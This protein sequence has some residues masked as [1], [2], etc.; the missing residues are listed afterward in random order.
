MSSVEALSQ[1]VQNLTNLFQKFIDNSKS[2]AQLEEANEVEDGMLI[3]VYSPNKTKLLKYPFSSP[4]LTSYQSISQK[5]EPEGYVGLDENSLISDG[6]IPQLEISKIDLLKDVFKVE[7]II[8]DGFRTSIFGPTNGTE[9]KVDDDQEDIT[10]KAANSINLEGNTNLFGNFETENNL[11]VNTTGSPVS[12]SLGTKIFLK[13]NSTSTGTSIPFWVD[14][15]RHNAN[16]TDAFF[17]GMLR[18]DYKGADYIKEVFSSY[19]IGRS[20]GTGFVNN[21]GGAI[22]L[23]SYRSSGGCETLFGVEAIANVDD[24]NGSSEITTVLNRLTAKIND[25]TMEIEDV[26]AASVTLDL[27]KGE[28]ANR[29]YVLELDC[30]QP[31]V[32]DDPLLNVDG[33]FAYIGCDDISLNFSA[34]GGAYFIKSEVQLPSKLSGPLILDVPLSEIVNGNSKRAINKEYLESLGLQTNQDA[35]IEV[36]D[37]FNNVTSTVLNLH[38]PADPIGTFLVNKNNARKGEVYYRHSQTEWIK[39]TGV[40]I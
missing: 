9:L 15:V 32:A 11:L 29:A 34:G 6:F 26:F 4:N 35:R 3:A 39:L 5:D 1:K 7:G 24:Y 27:K 16:S 22:I 20:S 19:H 37:N 21:L 33:D 28:I 25:A 31:S 38:R 18:A 17:G 8:D 14:S 2:Y 30:K 13:D 12:N 40:V 36:Y 10:L 23:G